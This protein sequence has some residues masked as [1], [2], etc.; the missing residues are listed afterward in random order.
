MNCAE[1]TTSS[2][3]LRPASTS[4]R[5]SSPSDPQLDLPGLEA[6]LAQGD[7]H[8][9]LEAGVDHRVGGHHHRLAWLTGDSIFTWANISGLSLSPGLEKRRRTLAVRVAS[10]R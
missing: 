6:A 2:P 8:V 9:L 4:R 1:V 5:P 7:E 10:L 3:P